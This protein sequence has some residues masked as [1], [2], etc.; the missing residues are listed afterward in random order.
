MLNIFNHI[1]GMK[2][3]FLLL[4]LCTTLS[5]T[6]DFAEINKNPFQPTQTDIGPLFNNVV[7]G[8]QLGWNEQLYM[9]NERLYDVTQ[10]GVKFA[11][12]F[13]N[14]T[15]GTEE[16]WNSTYRGLGQIREIERRIAEKAE[17]QPSETLNNIRAQL[18]I[19]TAYR[20]FRLTDLFG[21]VPFFEAGQGFQDLDRLRVEFDAQ[22]D[23]YRFLLEELQW[24][25]ERIR[26]VAEAFTGDGTP[27]ESLGTF[28]N[29]LG[30]DMLRWRKFGNSL[31]LR[32]ALRMS[33]KDPAFAAPIIRDILENDLPLIEEGEDVV[34]LPSAQDWRNDGVHWSFREHKKLRMGTNIW[35]QLS[36]T[37]APD[38]SGIYD[39]RAYIFFETNNADEWVPFPQHADSDTPAEG[40]IPYQEHRDVTYNVK[41]QDNLYSPFNYYLVRD[42]LGIPEIMLTAAEV[43]FCKAEAYLRGIGVPAD[44]SEAEGTYTLGV[45]ASLTFWQNIAQNSDF[46]E[47]KPPLLTQGDIFAVVNH[48]EIEIFTTDNKLERIYQQR[49]LDN[50]RQP[51]EA[52][53]LMRRSNYQTPLEGSP[54]QH[55][56]FVYPP[57]E[58]ENNPDEWAAQ[59]QRM[60]ADTEL[61]KVWWME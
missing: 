59:V 57:S 23:I 16:I 28:D 7:A 31:R 50:F 20:I 11:V 25:E 3:I 13:D 15:I 18:K 30:N 19:I 60:G 35:R 48:P 40:G 21:D 52:Y 33:E 24:A 47:N 22:E 26:P 14:V 4:L 32:Y 37:D 12:G 8:L 53:A 1:I 51:W 54:L 41:G 17:T 46:W 56:R 61:V 34:M 58:V 43:Q 45:V 39:P 9:H 36:A 10:L 38:G 6:K 27:Y 55:F 29:L 44:A 49:W 2:N 42:W 5:C